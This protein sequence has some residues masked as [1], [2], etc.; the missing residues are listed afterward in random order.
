[1]ATLSSD[2][3]QATVI[4]ENGDGDSLPSSVLIPLRWTGASQQNEKKKTIKSLW[5]D[6]WHRSNHR[7]QHSIW[8]NSISKFMINV[9]TCIS[10]QKKS[11]S[12]EQFI[13][14]EVSLFLGRVTTML[15]VVMWWNG[16]MPSARKTVLWTGSGW[17]LQ[18]ISPLLSQVCQHLFKRC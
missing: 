2:K 13:W 12:P 11:L 1:M 18:T 7:V 17:P 4:A 10:F 6:K 9:W 8:I 3:I 15:P 14:M 16:M 5:W